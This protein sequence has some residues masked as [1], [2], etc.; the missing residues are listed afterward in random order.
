MGTPFQGTW[1]AYLGIVTPLGLFWRDLWQMRPGSKVLNE[2]KDAEPIKDFKIYTCYS[3]NDR[4]VKGR[5]AI[6]KG[7][8]NVIPVP[9][10]HVSHFGFL[11]S[12]SVVDTIHQILQQHELIKES[13]TQRQHSYGLKESPSCPMLLKSAV[14]GRFHL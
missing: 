14:I 8:G 1:L 13:K 3:L 6:F 4:V 5:N 12:R 9:I 2:L 10:H 7:R 11:S